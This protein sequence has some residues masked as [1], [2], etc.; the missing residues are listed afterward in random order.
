MVKKMLSYK[1][2]YC[3]AETFIEAAPLIISASL[4]SFL[5]LVIF[6]RH[7]FLNQV[8]GLNHWPLV[9]SLAPLVAIMTTVINAAVI[10]FILYKLTKNATGSKDGDMAAVGAVLFFCLAIIVTLETLGSNDV[11]LAVILNLQGYFVPGILMTIVIGLLVAKIFQW[12]GKYSTLVLLLL[13]VSAVIAGIGMAWLIRQWSYI[14]LIPTITSFE[15]RYRISTVLVVAIFNTLASVLGFASPLGLTSADPLDQRNLSQVLTN[16]HGLA[17]ISFPA[18]IHSVYQTYAVA[19]SGM[20]LALVLLCLAMPVSQQKLRHQAKYSLLPVFFNVS[21][22]IT[23]LVFINPLLFIPALLSTVVSCLLPLLLTLT[24][25]MPIAVYPVSR[26]T[27]GILRGFLATDG[28]WW[29]LVVG[30]INVGLSALIYWPFLKQS[31]AAFS[32]RGGPLEYK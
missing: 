4:L 1:T 20:V 15:M 30:I 17:S 29:A 12:F 9:S 2:W 18:T 25:I 13:V 32:Q 5:H 19:G 14:D 16:Q 3:V 21:T 26:T 11:R 7:G 23:F 28:S 31:L 24:K 10:I 8:L 6:S 22:P 27:P